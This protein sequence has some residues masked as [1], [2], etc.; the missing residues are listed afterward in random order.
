MPWTT[1]GGSCAKGKTEEERIRGNQEMEQEEDK[2]TY[3]QIRWPSRA[4]A[5]TGEEDAKP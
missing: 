5:T 1:T 2:V 4:A 3:R